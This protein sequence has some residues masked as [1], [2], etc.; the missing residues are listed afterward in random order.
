LL[1]LGN[2]RVDY[3]SLD[4]EGSEWAIIQ[5]I[6]WNKVEIFFYR[7]M[8]QKA[9]LLNQMQNIS[10]SFLNGLAFSGTFGNYSIW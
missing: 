3:F 6:P 7:E 5:S 1:A 4:V 8:H 10:L 2:P 9:R